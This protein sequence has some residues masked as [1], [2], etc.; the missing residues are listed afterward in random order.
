MSKCGFQQRIRIA[1]ENVKNNS[2][3]RLLGWKSLLIDFDEKCH[4]RKTTFLG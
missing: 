4:P 2:G 1:Q 3:K